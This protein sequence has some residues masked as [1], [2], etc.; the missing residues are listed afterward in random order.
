MWGTGDRVVS[1][2]VVGESAA[3]LIT[4]SLNCALLSLRDESKEKVLWVDQICINQE[5]VTERNEQVQQMG[6]IYQCAERDIVWLGEGTDDGDR[7]VT[8][9][10]AM[11][12][13]WSAFTMSNPSERWAG[14][15]KIAWQ[16]Y[17]PGDGSDADWTGLDNVLRLNPVRNRVWVVQEVLLAKAVVLRYGSTD[18]DV[19]LLQRFFLATRVT[20]TP[21]R[22]PE[23]EMHFETLWY[24][25]LRQKTYRRSLKGLLFD[26]WGREATDPRDKIYGLLGIARW[27]NIAVDYSKTMLQVQVDTTKALM[28]QSG[29][30]NLLCFDRSMV[31]GLFNEQQL[32]SWVFDYQDLTN[33]EIWTLANS[34]YDGFGSLGGFFA[35]GLDPVS[36]LSFEFVAERLEASGLFIDTLVEV[37]GALHVPGDQYREDSGLCSSYVWHPKLFEAVTDMVH[38]VSHAIGHPPRTRD[39]TN[40]SRL[41]VHDQI[42][43]E[44]RLDEEQVFEGLAHSKLWAAA[45]TNNRLEKFVERQRE[46]KSEFLYSLETIWGADT[47]RLAITSKHKL[48]VTVGADAQVGDEICVLKAASVPLLLRKLSNQAPAETFRHIGTAYVHGIMDGEAWEQTD[49]FPTKLYRIV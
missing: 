32:P 46:A 21:P 38:K 41:L 27:I 20:H 3:I 5:N 43:T 7:A 18:I 16:S 23:L 49:K 2:H 31:Q 4:E 24:N 14:A 30:L 26:Y 35:V 34:D 12:D 11:L 17:E 33:P 48:I 47:R 10:A 8:R 44:D 1:I 19:D 29:T 37:Q 9:L 42:A 28:T 6:K 25:R 22:L 40:V 15:A 36:E 13:A 45:I 39:W